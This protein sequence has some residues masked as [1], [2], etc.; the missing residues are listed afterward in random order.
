MHN[1][2]DYPSVTLTKE[3]IDEAVELIPSTKVKRA[4]AVQ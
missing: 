2:T 1:K 4:I 3:M